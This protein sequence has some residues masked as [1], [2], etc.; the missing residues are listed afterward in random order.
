[1]LVFPVTSSNQKNCCLYVVD[2][3]L[4]V[5]CRAKP[6]SS[7][8]FNSENTALLTQPFF[9][10]TKPKVA[11]SF[12]TSKKIGTPKK[13]KN[14]PSSI[15]NPG[16]QQ[17]LLLLVELQAVFV[18]RHEAIRVEGPGVVE[19]QGIDRFFGRDAVQ[20]WRFGSLMVEG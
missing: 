11:V 1:M 6:Y 5:F 13:P 8:L 7:N 18:A 16:G 15:Y 20:A 10:E 2:D 9:I 3:Y 4:Y 17:E 12:S 14:H 19:G